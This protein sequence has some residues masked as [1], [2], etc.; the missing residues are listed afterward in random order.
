MKYIKTFE[1]YSINEEENIFKAAAGFFGQYNSDTR[2]RAEKAML[3]WSNSDVQKNYV[4]KTGKPSSQVEIFNKLREAYDN[5]SGLTL[6]AEN[7]VIFKYDET[8]L[9][10]EEVKK[11][12]EDI[13]CIIRQNEPSAFGIKN[14]NGKLEAYQSKSYSARTHGFGSGVAGH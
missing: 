14:L 6:P 3:D 2:E 10:S 9:S 5:N 12:F 13:C 8:T 1:S 4:K 7:S 11:L